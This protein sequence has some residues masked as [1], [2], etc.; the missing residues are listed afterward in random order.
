MILL[1]ESGQA[2]EES[3]RL[4]PREFKLG[5][6]RPGEVVFGSD[7]DAVYVRRGEG[8]I[9]RVPLGGGG[10]RGIRKIR[11]ASD[12][13]QAFDAARSEALVSPVRTPIVSSGAPS[14]IPR[15]MPEISAS[16]R[17]RFS[18]MSTASALRGDT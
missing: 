13:D 6:R 12:L 18:A 1:E 4:A 8:K 2:V 5:A 15:A 16:G 17:S 10:G 7:G 3:L 14:P 11:Q 9:Q